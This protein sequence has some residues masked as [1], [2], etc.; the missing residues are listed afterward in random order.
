[1]CSAKVYTDQS[2]Q[3]S[4]H[5]AKRKQYENEKEAI[6]K[7][8]VRV[9]VHTDFMHPALMAQSDKHNQNT[10]QTAAA[11]SH[12]DS[13]HELPPDVSLAKLRIAEARAQLDALKLRFQTALDNQF[14]L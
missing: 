9:G 1:M 12:L 8:L 13:Y 10:A 11:R 4:L 3:H 14:N 7:S 5:R 6:K 2:N